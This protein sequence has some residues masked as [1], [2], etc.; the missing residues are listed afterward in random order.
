MFRIIEACFS[1]V[2]QRVQHAACSQDEL[3]VARVQWRRHYG[4]QQGQPPRLPCCGGD[5][6][7]LAFLRGG[8]IGA[9]SRSSVRRLFPSS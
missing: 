6:H 9:T 5:T 3:V 2:Y 8:A 4:G 1:S 7:P